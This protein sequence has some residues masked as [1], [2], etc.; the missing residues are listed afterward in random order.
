MKILITGASGFVG[1]HLCKRLLSEGHTVYGLA[2]TPSK[3]QISH[4]HFI[5]VQGDL[6]LPD[7]LWTHDLPEDLDACIHAAG[8]VHSYVHDEFIQV[9]AFGT[10]YL[11]ESLKTKYSKDF[12]FIL[13]S[14]LA[15]AGPVNLGE[16]KDE[17]QMDFPVSHYGRSKKKAEEILKEHAP[18]QWICSIVRPP[19]IIG[20]GDV[21]VLDIFKMVKS[22]IVILP[23]M[24]SKRKEY[25][26]VCVFDL[27]ET[28][29]LLIKSNKSLFLYSAYDKTISFRELIEEIK[30][31]MG[32]SWLLYLP[33]PFFIIKILSFLLNLLYKLKNHNVRL[34]PDKICELKAMAWTCDNKASLIYL[35]QTYQ[36]P[37][38]RTIAMTLEDY[39]NRN[40]L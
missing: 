37:L 20:P 7:L 15:A 33:I 5:L 10:K 17:T 32:R 22:R 13:I 31:Q 8:I 11:I 18:S 12:K 2:R 34:T 4:P 3:M 36:Y 26:F 27:V 25:S 29:I 9:N 30:K 40:W 19:M 28:I 39:R 21:A 6:N 14:S 1:T 35:G 38:D 24:N 16:K 23:G